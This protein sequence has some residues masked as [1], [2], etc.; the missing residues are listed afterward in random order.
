VTLPST[1]EEQVKDQVKDDDNDP[2]FKSG[3][4]D[5]NAKEERISGNWDAGNNE[6]ELT[7]AR[8]KRA[9]R[10]WELGRKQ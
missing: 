10:T 5:F 9:S 1:R 8:R 6:S 2:M 4:T 7:M 3:S